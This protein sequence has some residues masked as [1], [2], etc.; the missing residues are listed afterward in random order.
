[1]LIDNAKLDQPFEQALERLYYELRPDFRAALAALPADGP[2]AFAIRQLQENA[3]I[4]GAS[5]APL[6]QDT[7]YIWALLELA[8]GDTLAGGAMSGFDAIAGRVYTERGLR[9]SLLRDALVERDNTGDNTPVMGEVHLL[10]DLAVHSKLH[11]MLKG[12]GSDNASRLTMLAPGAGTEGVVAE[13]VDAVRAKAANAC[14]PLLVG[15]GVG[16][17]FDKVAGLAKHALLRPVDQAN[18]DPRVAAIEADMLKRVNDLGIG[19]GGFGGGPTALAVHIET[20]PCHIA[21]LPLAVNLGC[22]AMRSTTIDL[23]TGEVLL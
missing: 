5:R 17:T 2:A 1:M 10:K 4:A 19:P 18:P 12:G 21:A 8:P 6:C 14:P 16:A 15:V 22:S 23:A 11:V 13:V 9:K 7:G 20:A 3:R